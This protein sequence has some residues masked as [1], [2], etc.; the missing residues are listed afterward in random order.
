MA[1]TKKAVVSTP[2]K[3]RPRKY[4]RDKI[5]KVLK[6]HEGKVGGLKAAH[7]ELLR[8]N[9]FGKKPFE[10]ISYIMVALI[11]KEAGVAFGRGRQPEKKEKKKAA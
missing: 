10:G 9:A 5:V 3:G 6:K 8:V 1:K 4:N 2:V 11:S 7:E